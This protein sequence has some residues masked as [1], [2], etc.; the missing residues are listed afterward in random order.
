ML[1]QSPADIGREAGYN[2]DGLPISHRADTNRLPFTLTFTPTDNLESPVNLTCMSSD[3][4]RKLEHLEK[5]HAGPGE[6]ERRAFLSNNLNVSNCFVGKTRV[7][8][9]YSVGFNSVL[10]Q[11][12]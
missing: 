3:R 12:L 7:N 1:E 5:T 9:F 2:L 6:H 4:G 11:F 10:Q 8:I